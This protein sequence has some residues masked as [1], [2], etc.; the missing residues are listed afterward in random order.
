MFLLKLL[1]APLQ[2]IAYQRE[3]RYFNSL[4]DVLDF[5]PLANP[6]PAVVRSITFLV[7]NFTRHSGGHTSILR[8][9]TALADL[10]FDVGYVT[11]TPQ[12][13]EHMAG[14]ARINL[15]GF[16]G[17]CFDRSAMS[18]RH[19]DVWV[20][21]HWHTAYHLRRVNGYKVYFIQDY[22]PYFYPVG[23][24]YILARSTYEFGF[25]M[26]SLGPWIAAEIRRHLPSAGPVDSIDFPYERKEYQP[27]ERDFD[28]YP[29]KKILKI[30]VYL[31]YSE[32]RAPFII[33]GMLGKAAADLRRRGTELDIRY[34]GESR[35]FKLE[36]GRNLGKLG[37][38]QLRELYR[39]SD[40]GMVA[41]LT[42]I[43][44]VPYEMIATNLPLIEFADGSF[45]S[46]MDPR[47]AILVSFAWKDLANRLA[48]AATDPAAL[49]SM[50]QLARQ[51]LDGLG[52]ERSAARRAHRFG[53]PAARIP[54]H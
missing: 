17:T 49:R 53:A 12:T 47:A 18:S 24:K 2:Q 3:S 5:G 46:F 54:R 10:G 11:I 44:L 34:F 22:E 43:S 41:S 50:T 25:R 37:G 38:E 39:T 8:L 48:A 6:R 16:K 7:H 36:H 51:Q 32:R 28:G 30:A 21:T 33:Q 40:F 42:N 35:L 15:P 31:K 29:R 4:L 9:G 14:E 52:W 19:S 23:E 20:A 13:A 45:P 27:I 1:K 26:I